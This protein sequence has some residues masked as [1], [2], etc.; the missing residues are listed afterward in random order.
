MNSLDDL[1]NYD[2]G[3]QDYI[4][5]RLIVTKQYLENNQIT[6]AIECLDTVIHDI[7]TDYDSE[8]N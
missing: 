1:M 3:K 2:K 8:L 7:E 5:A 4:L 6:D